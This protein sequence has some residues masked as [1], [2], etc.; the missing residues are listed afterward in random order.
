[1]TR[2]KPKTIVEMLAENA[3]RFP[4]KT[5]IRFYNR[6]TTYQIL[7][8]ES[9]SLANFLVAKG[10]GLGDR[11]GLLVDKTPEVITSFL[12]VTRAGGAVLPI[13]F[14]QPLHQ[15]QYLFD[16]TRPRIL[17]VSESH[18]H[19]L[20]CLT[21]PENH[22]CSVIIGTS[23]SSGNYEW[24]H[25]IENHKGGMCQVSVSLDNVAYLNLTSGTTGSPKCAVTTHANIFWNTYCAIKALCLTSDDVHLCLFPVFAHPHELL[26]RPL[27]LG[28]TLVL[29]DKISPKTIS[30]VISQNGITCMMAIASIYQALIR[31][32]ESA[33]F[34]LPTL[35]L[36]ESGGMHTPLTLLKEFEERFHRRITPV[37]GS[38]ETTGIALAMTPDMSYKPGSVGKPCL[39]H[40]VGYNVRIVDG[41]GMDV[42]DGEVGEMI[43]KGP[44]VITSYFGDADETRKCLKDDWLYT[45]DM[46]KKDTQGYFYFAGRQQG[47][48]K[49][50][51]LKVYP[52]EIEE[53]LLS[54][55]DVAEAVVVKVQDVLHGEI[56][57]AIIVLKE[58]VS[59]DK[60]DV[61]LFCEQRLSKYKI[62]RIIEF[63]S[64]LPKTSGGKI[65]WREL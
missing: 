31:L 16:L 52:I 46:F 10:L 5:A 54:H 27:Y 51:G 49:V 45:G 26:A 47:M 34:E 40:G 7:H 12:G 55:P 43:I 2:L 63:L 21:L 35:R 6:E 58:N 19:L 11:V 28:G 30:S 18:Q 61:R 4:E 37:W 41:A 56:P 23:D 50:A 36:P 1:M 60:R 57:R 29:L 15:M 39:I 24:D 65:L 53:T 9:N 17:I 59:L 8:Q 22:I 32:H 3:E 25:V 44:G 38:T 33:P 42:Q 62:P 48:M 64:E 20:S 13:D 14:N